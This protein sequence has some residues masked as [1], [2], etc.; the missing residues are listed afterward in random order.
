MLTFKKEKS[1]RVVFK[2]DAARKELVREGK[3]IYD[4]VSTTLGS[5]GGNVLIKDGYESPRVQKDG[6]TVA[7]LSTGANTLESATMMIRSAAIKTNNEVGDGTTST[8]VLAYE[9]LK[10]GADKIKKYKLNSTKV[11]KGIDLAVADVFSMLTEMSKVGNIYDIAMVSSN[12]DSEISKL[13]V[14]AYDS[15][16][17]DGMV[18]YE[19]SNKSKSEVDISGGIM[20]EGGFIHPIYGKDLV[21][22]PI[23]Y[24]DCLMLIV[25]D[26][27]DK[28]D[29][30]KY[31]FMYSE[32]EHKPL[33]F[34]SSREGLPVKN[35]L[36]ANRQK[37]LP[38]I[39]VKPP[40][41]GEMKSILL[42]DIS[43]IIGGKII[44]SAYGNMVNLGI[45]GKGEEEKINSA[46]RVLGRV[47]KI[48][49]SDTKTVIF[50]YESKEA[51]DYIATI[52]GD[53]NSERK[54]IISGKI[55]TIKLGGNSEIEQDE[56]FTRLEDA[57]H[58]VKNALKE[59]VVPGAGVSLMI[60]RNTINLPVNVLYSDISI[61]CGYEL[62]IESLGAV[63]YKVAENSKI[64]KSDVDYHFSFGKLIN[65]NT[66]VPEDLSDTVII[67]PVI[68]VRTALINAASIASTLLT[69]EFY[70]RYQ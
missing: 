23:E 4:A 28:P 65:V 30:L 10:R 38:L 22:K 24:N 68:T 21:G 53:D 44:G 18:Y 60:V 32:R 54:A 17:K 31:I 62:L 55:A 27:F 11:K 41:F 46:G 34:M 29:M 36:I 33:V 37:S 5:S 64:S 49:V 13:I 57:I 48:I 52:E 39:D 63:A 26:L 1:G 47:K 42:S 59:G 12:N 61:K 14:D 70:V 8:T 2:G 7:V 58:S 20:I 6:V 15:V 66:G 9:I 45:E 56:R 35:T 40:A 3:F 16:G 25:D 50:P 69:T 51:S 67:D 43:K 19:K